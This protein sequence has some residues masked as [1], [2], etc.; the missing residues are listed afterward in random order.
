L[1]S[2]EIGWAGGLLY[3]LFPYMRLGVKS[4]EEWLEYW[5][6]LDTTKWKKSSGE[7]CECCKTRE[8]AVNN[9]IDRF[10]ANFG[11]FERGEYNIKVKE[12]NLKRAKFKRPRL[13]F[14]TSTE[15]F[16]NGTRLFSNLL[17]RMV[18]DYKSS[19]FRVGQEMYLGAWND[20]AEYLLSHQRRENSEFYCSDISSFDLTFDYVNILYKVVG[21][22]ICSAVASSATERAYVF[23]YLRSFVE[24][25]VFTSDGTGYEFEG[26]IPSGDFLHGLVSSLC[27]IVARYLQYRDFCIKSSGQVPK[28]EEAID[29]VRLI[30]AAD[31]FMCSGPLAF[32]NYLDTDARF[33]LVAKAGSS[34][35]S[36]N[37]RRMSFLGKKFKLVDFKFGRMFMPEA[38]YPTKNLYSLRFGSKKFGTRDML[39]RAK[40]ILSVNYWTP[41]RTQLE[42]VVLRLED[43]LQAEGGFITRGER[44]DPVKL[45]R[46]YTGYQSGYIETRARL[47][48]LDV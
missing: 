32:L 31:D 48:R 24:K 37:L 30:A 22:W 11:T 33:N 38:E 14:I 1:S 41:Y 18:T 12:E 2:E 7:S 45:E 42:R 44:Y 20:L 5:K 10:E 46:L 35:I 23:G 16:Y 26:A 40:S 43:Q 4:H 27:H 36:P 15:R 3:T 9:H 17:E 25:V 29:S 13:F 6:E 19:A 47:N 8:D 28:P 34:C 21:P 39:G